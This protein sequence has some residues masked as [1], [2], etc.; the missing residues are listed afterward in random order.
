MTK[1]KLS[2]FGH[3]MQ[4]KSLEKDI[5]LG[6]VSG[7]RRRGHPRTRWLDTIKKDT[8]LNIAE[9]KEAVRDRKTWRTLI[10]SVAESR[11]RLN[12]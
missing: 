4:S 5:M 10:H 11:T 3:I 1:Q 7:K 8:E 2:Y 6:M 9:L 12:G